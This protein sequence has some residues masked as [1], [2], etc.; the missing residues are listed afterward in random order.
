[1]HYYK[2]NIGDYASHTTHLDPL[3]DIAY[4]RMIDWCYL[5]E[6]HL[7]KD[8]DEI[9]RI[10]RMRTHSDC[11]A[12][13]LREFFKK[14]ASG[15]YCNH[16]EKE[17]NAYRD[18]SDKAKAS[19]EARWNK[20]QILTKDANAMRTHSE[21]NANHKPITNNHKPID[22]GDKSPPSARFTPPTL[23]DIKQYCKDNSIIGVDHNNFIDFYASKG[24][25]VGKN[26]MKDWKAAVRTWSRRNK[27]EEP[28]KPTISK[29]EQTRRME[30]IEQESRRRADARRI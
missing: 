9:S 24:W 7:P 25:M 6:K 20:K 29:E 3:E 4:R 30:F 12:N 28:Q 1:M 14:S 8:V 2:F 11:I 5:H 21:G 22:K 26:K 10:I 15:Y 19:A 23:E 16:I 17:I 27:T 18:K 13:V